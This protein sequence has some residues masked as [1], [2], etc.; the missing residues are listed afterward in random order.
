[1]PAGYRYQGVY[2]ISAPRKAYKF[3]LVQI[4]CRQSLTSSLELIPASVRVTEQVK[5]GG[6]MYQAATKVNVLSFEI[7]I[8]VEADAVY[9]SGKQHGVRRYGKSYFG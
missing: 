4:Q 5:P 3:Q 2:Y 7:Y 9:I 6:G 8:I 1:M